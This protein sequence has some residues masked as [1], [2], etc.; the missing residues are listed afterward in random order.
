MWAYLSQGTG[1]IDSTVAVQFIIY[2]DDLANGGVAVTKWSSVPVNTTTILSTGT[3]VVR[4]ATYSHSTT[5]PMHYKVKGGYI[6]NQS[7]AVFKGG[8]WTD[9]L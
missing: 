5:N 9:A 6:N 8:A 2:V 7:V 3:T 1:Y 4:T